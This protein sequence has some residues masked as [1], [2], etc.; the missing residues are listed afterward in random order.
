VDPILRRFTTPLCLR[1]HA[2]RSHP[3]YPPLSL[4]LILRVVYKNT[5]LSCIFSRC[6]QIGFGRGRKGKFQK[7]I[8]SGAYKSVGEESSRREEKR[9]KEKYDKEMRE[10]GEQPS[11]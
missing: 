7:L 10:M 3:L 5:P 2:P 1:E 6:A 4:S 8:Y 11:S 9:E